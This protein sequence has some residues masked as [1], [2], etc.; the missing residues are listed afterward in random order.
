MQRTP[1]LTSRSLADGA[2]LRAAAPGDEAGLLDSIQALAV[3]EREPDAVANS[4]ALLTEALFGDD[5]KVFAHVVEREGRIRGIA[6]WFVTYSTWTG[7][8]GIW[9]EDLFV[10][11]SERGRGYGK[12]LLSSLAEVAVAR[13]YSRLE[14]TVLDWNA[15]S[16]AFYRSVGAEPMDEWTTQRMSGEALEILARR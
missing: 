14:W 15:P 5:P 2:V 9:L 1:E 10:D 13:G 7:R 8:H 3:Y 4:E 12:A 11:G 6:I 16:I